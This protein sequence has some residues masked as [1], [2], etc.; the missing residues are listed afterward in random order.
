MPNWTSNNLFILADEDKA[1]A[2]A[3]ALAGPGDWF[4]PGRL[5][6]DL[7][8]AR[9]LLTELSALERARI[10]ARRGEIETEIR[11]RHG[12]PETASFDFIDLV[13]QCKDNG[14]IAS[15]R[16]DC[17]LSLARLLPLNE[18]DLARLWSPQEDD[19]RRAEALISMRHAKIG[20]KW[21]PSFDEAASFEREF[22]DG[23]ACVLSLAFSTPWGAVREL[24]RLIEPVTRAHGGLALAIISRY[25][26]SENTDANYLDLVT[27][28]DWADSFDVEM[29]LDADD[30][31][32]YEDYE[33]LRLHRAS[34]SLHDAFPDCRLA[35]HLLEI[36]P[37]P[38]CA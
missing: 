25:E 17:P 27:G 38:E 2:L 23:G 6:E 31:P 36:H 1:D 12:L 29:Q 16:T 14:Q 22:V 9:R 24:E 21:H 18:H 7:P 32:L 26:G 28:E 3:A 34:L 13:L 10:A 8:P 30:E 11:K 15:Y 20:V 19:S 5:L 33:G 35:R 4:Y 37:E